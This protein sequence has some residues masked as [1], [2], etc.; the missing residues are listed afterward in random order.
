MEERRNILRNQKGFTL[1]EIIAVLV[2]LGILAAVAVPKYLDLQKQANASALRAAWAA[3]Q[4]QAVMDY[5]E[6]VLQTPTL[7][8]TYTLAAT[9]ATVGDFA[10]TIAVANTGIGTVVVTHDANGAVDAANYPT[11]Q[12]FTKTFQVYNP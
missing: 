2:I 8:G 12:T 10:V 7:A 1:I 5:S 6:A 3:G 9:A 4:S 11:G